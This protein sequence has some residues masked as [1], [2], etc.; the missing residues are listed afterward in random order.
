[1]LVLVPQREG[2]LGI[3]AIQPWQSDETP[4]RDGHPQLAHLRAQTGGADPDRAE[5][6]EEQ[7]DH[8]QF[9][10]ATNT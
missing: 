4:T 7:S 6:F 2:E 5:D 9:C 8:Y 10:Q 1:M 3:R